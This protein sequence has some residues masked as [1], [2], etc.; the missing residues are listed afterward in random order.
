MKSAYVIDKQMCTGCLAC[1]DTC[2][3]NAIDIFI[4]EEGFRYPQINQGKCIKCGKC[5]RFCAVKRKEIQYDKKPI[6][7]IGA[8][9]KDEKERITSR[10]GGV[11]I[12]MANYILEYDG[13]VY[14]CKLGENLEVYHS[15]ATNKKEVDEFKGSKYVESDLKDVYREVKED[16]INGKNVLFSGTGCQIAGLN[17]ALKG[18]NTE[19]LYT[20]DII[21]HGVPSPLIYKE[22]L[23]YM[24]KRENSKVIGIDF[25]DKSF[26]WNTHRETLTYDD[27]TTTTKYYTE[28]FYSHHTLRPSC[29]NCQ[30]S[31]MDRVSDITIGDFWGID[32]ENQEFND[33]KGV[34]LV[35]VNTTKGKKMIEEIT[36]DIEWIQVYT[37]HYKQHNLHSPSIKPEDRNQFWKEYKENGFEFILKKYT[38]Y[39]KECVKN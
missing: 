18:I 5:E 39:S 26:G 1:K 31:N 38:N 34:S 35:L 8:K 14:G 23:K 12:S 37:E 2:P 3:V 22:F 33:N 25:R 27:K 30:F 36:K 13:V 19:K 29:Y 11:F 16:L 10:S 9:V 7:I 20:I 28:L 21:C 15:R 17:V 24:E 32:K 6:E 4:D